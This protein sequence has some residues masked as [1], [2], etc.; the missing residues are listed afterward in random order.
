MRIGSVSCSSLMLVVCGTASLILAAG[1][2]AQ[3][4]P[5]SPQN[6]ILGDARRPMAAE[7]EKRA[8][9]MKVDYAVQP[10]ADRM[11]PPLQHAIQCEA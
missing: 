8:F 6:G 7:L 5:H 10:P 2:K 9:D 4:G 11:T 3:L 1:C